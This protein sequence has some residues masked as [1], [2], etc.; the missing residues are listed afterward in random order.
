MTYLTHNPHA[1]TTYRV[2]NGRGVVVGSTPVQGEKR[3]VRFRLESG[4]V[5]AFEG[6]VED[7]PIV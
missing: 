4:E 1:A 7:I 5:L 2:H 6:V 3:Y